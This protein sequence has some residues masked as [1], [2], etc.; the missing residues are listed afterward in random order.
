[1]VG[2]IVP[3]LHNF[4]V[5][6]ARQSEEERKKKK[7]H[8]T[9]QKKRITLTTISGFPNTAPSNYIQVSLAQSLS[10]LLSLSHPLLPH[11]SHLS[12]LRSERPIRRRLSA[13][14]LVIGAVANQWL[15]DPLS[16]CGAAFAAGSPINQTKTETRS[17]TASDVSSE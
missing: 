5:A 14:A 13:S 12:L 16:I 8:T 2:R 1:M 9:K 10:D 3:E 4:S 11:T 15:A 6:L 7:P 17:Q